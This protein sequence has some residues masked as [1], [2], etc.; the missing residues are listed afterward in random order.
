MV[1]WLACGYLVSRSNV[2]D[3]VEIAGPLGSWKIKV[4]CFLFALY[5]FLMLDPPGDYFLNDGV[6]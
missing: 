4:S 1:S 3:M 6:V 2:A 5:P